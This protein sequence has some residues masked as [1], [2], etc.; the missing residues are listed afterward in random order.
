MQPFSRNELCGLAM[1]NSAIFTGSNPLQTTNTLW[2]I[3]AD[4]MDFKTSNYGRSEIFS[5]K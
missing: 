1:W 2:H 3:H 5:D 4:H